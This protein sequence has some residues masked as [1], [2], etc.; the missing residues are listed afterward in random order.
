[1]TIASDMALPEL[2]ISNVEREEL[3]FTSEKRRERPAIQDWLYHW[4]SPSG[5]NLLSYGQQGSY[6]WLSFRGLADFQISRDVREITGYPAQEIAP[7]TIR[8]LLLDQ[9]LPRCLAH[10]G[11]N[12]L[13]ASAIQYKHGLLLFIGDSGAG[14]STLAG[15]FHQAGQR[16]VSDD[17]LWIKEGEDQVVAVPTYGGL[18]LWEDSL[19]FLF[20]SDKKTTN[21]AHYSSKKRVQLEESAMPRSEH[22]VPVLAVIVLSPAEESREVKLEKLPH[23][24]AFIAM[25]KQTFQLDPTDLERM[26][27]HVQALGRIVPRLKSFRLSMPHDYALLPLAR[28]KILEAVL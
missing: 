24:E 26:T 20:S 1:M 18:R 21:M 11:R 5:E 12:M 28:Q 22:G 6:H 25:L 15:N 23:R 10:Q 8:H 7:E 17:C 2:S 16:A 19:R 13:H 4:F 3:V 14:K 27:R 9:V